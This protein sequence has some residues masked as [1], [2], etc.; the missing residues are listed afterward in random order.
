TVEETELLQKIYDLLTAKDFQTRMAGVALLLDLCK[1]SPRLISNNIVQIF[2][3]FV[4]RICDY[5]KKVKQQALEALVSMIATLRDAL[6]P[7]LIRLVEAITNNLNSKHLGIYGAAVK[8]L[9]ASITHIDKVLVLKEFSKRMSQLSGQA[10]LDVTERL[11]VLVAHVYPRSP[12]VVQH[13]ALPVLWS[14]LGNKVLPVRS[15]NIRI[16]VVK[17]AKALHEAMGSKLRQHAASQ[18]QNV[19]KNLSDIL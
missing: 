14:F 6:K 19:M 3:Y 2:D 4:L 5:N 12:E 1:S 13:Y 15:A 18:P 7:V 9:E 8:A 16:V 17:L 10:L 11:S